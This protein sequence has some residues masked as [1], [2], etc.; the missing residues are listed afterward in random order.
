MGFLFSGT[1]CTDESDICRIAHI[2]RITHIITHLQACQISMECLK[3]YKIL[4]TV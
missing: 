3:I 4:W 2:G 1:H